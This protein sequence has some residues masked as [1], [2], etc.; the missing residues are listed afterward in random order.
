MSLTSVRR[1]HDLRGRG[2]VYL[3][4]HR[5]PEAPD[6]TSTVVGRFAV[7]LTLSLLSEGA[8]RMEHTDIL[9]KEAFSYF[10]LCFQPFLLLHFDATGLLWP[11]RTASDV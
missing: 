11:H 8:C 9:I 4:H 1:E 7:F 5:M 10:F 2:M 6:G 3:G